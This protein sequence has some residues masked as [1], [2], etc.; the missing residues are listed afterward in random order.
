MKKRNLLYILPLVFAVGCEPEF[1]DVDFNNGT[2]D[3]SRTVAV[4]N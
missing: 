3:F 2:A 4:G 1:D